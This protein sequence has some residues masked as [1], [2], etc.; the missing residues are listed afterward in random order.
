LYQSKLGFDCHFKKMALYLSGSGK[1]AHTLVILQCAKDEYYG[2]EPDTLTGMG[3]LSFHQ[4]IQEAAEEKQL[5]STTVF[6]IEACSYCPR[7]LPTGKKNGKK[8]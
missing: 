1:K 8:I 2:M 6:C 3:L 4:A 7:L 5:E